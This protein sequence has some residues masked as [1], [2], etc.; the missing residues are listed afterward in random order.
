MSAK[1]RGALWK[2]TGRILPK[3][4]NFPSERLER[5]RAPVGQAGDEDLVDEVVHDALEERHQDGRRAAAA[6]AKEGAREFRR[7]LPTK[8]ETLRS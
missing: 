1:T 2:S 7:R 5:N 3:K 4:K 8:G 6:A